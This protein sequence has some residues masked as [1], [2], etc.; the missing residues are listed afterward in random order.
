MKSLGSVFDVAAK[1]KFS[2]RLYALAHIILSH[3]TRGRYAYIDNIFYTIFHSCV[4][5]CAYAYMN[6][7]EDLINERIYIVLYIQHTYNIP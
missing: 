6:D 7:S 3:N 1:W 5:V 4:S 2:H